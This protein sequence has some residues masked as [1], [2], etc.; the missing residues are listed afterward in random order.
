MRRRKTPAGVVVPDTTLDDV[1]NNACADLIKLIGIYLE[2]N[3][4]SLLIPLVNSRRA[5]SGSPPR[6]LQDGSKPHRTIDDEHVDLNT[7]RPTCGVLQTLSRT[8]DV[9]ALPNTEGVAAREASEAAGLTDRVISMG[10]SFP[11]AGG[12][13]GTRTRYLA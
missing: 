8:R 6:T 9:D 12:C 3:A 11:V 5:G 7:K 1:A 10:Q 2:N 13:G 4:P